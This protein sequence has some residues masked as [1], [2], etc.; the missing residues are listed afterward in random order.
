[1][2]RRTGK[3]DRETST[4]IAA[5]IERRTAT[6]HALVGAVGELEDAR[7]ARQEAEDHERSVYAAALEAQERAVAD[8]WTAAELRDVGLYVGSPVTR[9]RRRGSGGVQTD[10]AG[11]SM[12]TAAAGAGQ[13]A[14]GDAGTPVADGADAPA[15]DRTTGDGSGPLEAVG[16]SGRP[17]PI[18]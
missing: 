17:V 12:G 10:P 4:A 8:G 3:P 16:L 5:L 1:M 18:G 13:D 7:A 11:D 15:D 14:A 6:L 9:R 2:A